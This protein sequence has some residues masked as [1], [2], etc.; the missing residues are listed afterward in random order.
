MGIWARFWRWFKRNIDPSITIVVCVVM[1]TLSA[2]GLFG[3]NLNIVLSLILV[4]LALLAIS[5]IRDREANIHQ[6]EHHVRSF[7]QQRAACRYLIEYASHYRAREA[8]L[9]QYSCTTSFDL[10][11]FLL[12]QGTHVT[13]YVQH[14]EV[15]ASLGSQGQK[16]RIKQTIRRLQSYIRSNPTKVYHLK[17]YKYR[18]LGTVSAIRIDDRVI[19]LGSYTYEQVDPTRDQHYGSD[20]IAISGDDRM[21]IVAFGE[22]PEYQAL[23]A[24]FNAIEH[25]YQQKREEVQI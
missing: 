24:T 25:E 9:L 7:E 16:E 17:L 5:I 4:V 12:D 3:P 2:A 19:S 15:P 10:A 20:T 8:T 21:A 22:T 11:C 13:I 1:G 18:T 6:E 23:N 14:E